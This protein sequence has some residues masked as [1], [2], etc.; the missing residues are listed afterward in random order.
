[1][2][3]LLQHFLIRSINAMLNRRKLFA[4]SATCVFEIGS[5]GTISELQHGQG[6]ESEFGKLGSET[7]DANPKG[8]DNLWVLCVCNLLGKLADIYVSVGG[9]CC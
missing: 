9:N 8:L 2:A 7:F 5:K 6:A 3:R 4:P 1:M